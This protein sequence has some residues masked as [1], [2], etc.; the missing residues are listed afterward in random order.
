MTKIQ[1]QRTAIAI[2][3]LCIFRAGTALSSPRQNEADSTAAEMQTP[4]DSTAGD[5]SGWIGLPIAF[6]TPETRLGAGASALYTFRTDGS[7]R[8]STIGF[9]LFL[10]QEDQVVVAISP[11]FYLRQDR[12]RL[13]S[14]IAFSRYPTYFWG[15]GNDTPDDTKE[16]YTPR[17]FNMSFSAQRQ[18][19]PNVRIGAQYE[20]KYQE[21]IEV[22]EDGMLSSGAIAGS[23][24]YIISGIGLLATWDSRDNIFYSTRGSFF[25]FST[26]FYPS[27]L[28]SDYSYTKLYLDYRKFFPFGTK[29]VA[30]LRSPL[31]WRAST[32]FTRSSSSKSLMM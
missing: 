16:Q 24:K 1:I 6:Y 2:A 8:P 11:E 26:Y 12:V 23:D 25:N 21:M 17:L 29:Q 9:I 5:R 18:V 10:T 31:G 19:I 22:E 20:L 3:L 4:A 28:G 27:W 13:D 15:V 30:A 7:T 14:D 32:T